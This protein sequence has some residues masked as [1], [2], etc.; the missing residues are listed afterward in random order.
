MIWTL[1]AQGA[2][3][4]AQLSLCSCSSPQDPCQHCHC[5]LLLSA[6]SYVQ[7]HL[8]TETFLPCVTA[9]CRNSLTLCSNAKNLPTSSPSAFFL[10]LEES[11]SSC[12]VLPHFCSLPICCGE[13][14][15]PCS[16]RYSAHSPAVLCLAIGTGW[17]CCPCGK[18]S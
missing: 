18:R 14:R 8:G 3:L 7:R 16:S 15:K 10:D 12:R 1:R 9:K 4:L 13:F 6:T 2:T 17:R 11:V 5:W